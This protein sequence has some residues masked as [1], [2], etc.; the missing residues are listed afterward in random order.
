MKILVASTTL[1]IGLASA[2]CAS[3]LPEPQITPEPA[4]DRVEMVDWSGLYAGGGFSLYSGQRDYSSGAQYDMTGYTIDGI[5]GYRMQRG[6]WVYGGEVSYS[7]GEVAVDTNANYRFSNLADL[8]G[9]VG[10]SFGNALVF[11]AAG[12]S[13][14]TWH[15]STSFKNISK[16]MNAGIG[17]DF[18]VSDRSFVGAEYI[19]RQQSGQYSPSPTSTFDTDIHAL[20]VRAGFKF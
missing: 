11:V 17:V 4:V 7:S 5:A 1:A 15:E 2:A 9:Q 12:W 16:G 8:R 10:Y 3:G 13:V 20:R 19:Y 6:A 14:G 18:K